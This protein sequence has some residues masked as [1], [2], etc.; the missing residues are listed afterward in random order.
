MF[1]G[2][3]WRDLT[4]FQKKRSLL[5]EVVVRRGP[6]TSFENPLRILI[7]DD[8]RPTF[9]WTRFYSKCIVK[10]QVGTHCRVKSPMR[11]IALRNMYVCLELNVHLWPP[12]LHN[13]AQM[14]SSGEFGDTC[15]YR[16]VRNLPVTTLLPLTIQR[17]ARY[18]TDKY[19]II[20]HLTETYHLRGMH[21]S[22]K[23]ACCCVG[24]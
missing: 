21:R 12:E 17:S 10:G 4:E 8:T 15:L 18:E 23:Y 5:S 13:L 19:D 16:L 7:P 3:Q 22:R 11:F 9:V 20:E 2:R 24:R 1:R 14:T 6:D